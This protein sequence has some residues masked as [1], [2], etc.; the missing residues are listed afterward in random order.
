MEN[1]TEANISIEITKYLQQDRL[2]QLNTYRV[3]RNSV[4]CYVPEPGT[5]RVN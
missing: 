4:M 2:Y 5:T 3:K 1:I